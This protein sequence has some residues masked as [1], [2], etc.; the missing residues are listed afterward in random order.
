M[1]SDR[2][3]RSLPRRLESSSEKNLGEADLVEIVLAG[4]VAL[5]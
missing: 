1:A 5:E 3:P 2:I 4:L